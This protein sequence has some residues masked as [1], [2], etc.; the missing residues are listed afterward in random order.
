MPRRS[1]SRL[2]I[3]Y[4]PYDHTFDLSVTNLAYG[5]RTSQV[6][7]VILN[8]SKVTTFLKSV[9]PRPVPVKW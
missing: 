1:E 2:T 5:T 7:D 6:L 8:G 9:W 4:N 3:T